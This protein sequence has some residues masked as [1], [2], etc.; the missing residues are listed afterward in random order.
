MDKRT[1]ASFEFASFVAEI[2]DP[3]TGA[4]LSS[5]LAAQLGTSEDRLLGDWEASGVP[6]WKDFA[7]HVLALLDAMHDITMAL[8]ATKAWYGTWVL[9]ESRG[10]TPA[11]CVA[12][13]AFR[14]ALAAVKELRQASCNGSSSIWKKG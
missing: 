3:A 2:S 10:W 5:R 14:E 1:A 12:H 4:I 9:L 7:Q 6:E 8:S 13:G 11:E